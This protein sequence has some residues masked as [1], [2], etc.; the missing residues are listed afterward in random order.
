LNGR[1]ITIILPMNPP[2]PNGILS[3]AIEEVGGS[4]ANKLP[5]WLSE[6]SLSELSEP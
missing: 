5:D 6:L 2:K 3:K 1:K 4:R